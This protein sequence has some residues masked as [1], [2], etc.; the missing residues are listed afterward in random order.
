MPKSWKRWGLFAMCAALMSGCYASASPYYY[1]ADY[2]GA[3]HYRSYGYYAPPA[4]VVR[5]RP[6]WGYAPSRAYVHAY[7]AAPAHHHRW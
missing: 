3:P 2:Y 1:G 4:V 5:A 7:R 6:A